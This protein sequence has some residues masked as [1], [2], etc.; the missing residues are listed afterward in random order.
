M[1][2]VSESYDV[3]IVGGGLVGATLA[4]LLAEKGH[5][6]ALIEAGA[7]DSEVPETANDQD[8]HFDPRVVALTQASE[9]LFKNLGIWA[10]VAQ[11]RVCPYQ[12]MAVWDGDGTGEIVF[13]AHEANADHLGVIVENSL[14]LAH[15]RQALMK[16][17]TVKLLSNT[18]VSQLGPMAEHQGQGV[19]FLGLNDGRV[20]ATKVLVAAD[21]ALSAVRSMASFAM[22]EWSYNHQAI[23]TTVRTEQPHQFTARQVF[24]K[25]GPLAY[26]P[27][28]THQGD[29]H[30][31]SIV[32]SQEPERAEALMALSDQ[33]FCEEIGKALEYRLGHVT[34]VDQRFSIPLRQRHAKQYTKERIALIG[35]AAHTI[36]PLAGQGVNLGLLDA[37]VLAEELLRSL[38]AGLDPGSDR[39]L[40]RYQR[41]RMGHNLSM[42]AVMESFKQLFAESAP[43][44]RFFR[45]AGMSLLNQHPLLKRS[46]LTRAMG[47]EG[48]LPA[49]AKA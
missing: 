29:D 35:D 45:N 24:M 14:L 34:Q 39:T 31:C 27:L 47:L 3:A 42:M 41:R 7:F 4:L 18:K 9:I 40:K 30:Y 1:D 33:A 11:N 46:I 28:Q 16:S 25:E 13:H 48:D 8:G 2:A 5:S 38:D 32:W 15:L 43:P 21:G 6:I 10:S 20:I 12:T 17:G 22:R 26:L 36:H 23:V 49:M 44:V 37:A 19:R